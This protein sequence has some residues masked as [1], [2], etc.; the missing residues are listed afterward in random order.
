MKA[1]GA[2]G[3][4]ALVF[5]ILPKRAQ[6][7]V[8]GS[9]MR[10][11]DP[12]GLKNSSGTLINPATEEKQ[13]VP[14]TTCVN[15]AVTLTTADTAYRL[16]TSEL[17]DRKSITIHNA[18]DTD[19]YIGGSSVTTSNGILLPVGGTMTLD[20]ESGIYGVCGTS[21]KTLNIMESK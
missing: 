17:A 14:F 1:L 8:F 6:A 13:T 15:T 20:A 16:P 10:A 4:S 7:L 5:S 2:A 19:C 9:S 3:L 21:N 12:I 11:P 18:S